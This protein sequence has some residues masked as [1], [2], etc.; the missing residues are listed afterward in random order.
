[1]PAAAPRIVL[2]T[3]AAATRGEGDSALRI[4][5][6]LAARGREVEL[7]RTTPGDPIAGAVIRECPGLD[8]VWRHPFALRTLGHDWHNAGPRVLVV[9]ERGAAEIGLSLAERH[10]IP[11]LLTVDDFLEPGERLRVSRGWC[12][13]ILAA[14]DELAHD[15]IRNVGL[16]A[17]LVHVIHP[18]VETPDPRPPA[19]EPSPIVVIG[20]AGPLSLDGG[21]GVFLAAARRVIDQGVDAE[22]IIAGSGEDEHE[23]RRRAERSKIVERVT[24]VADAGDD[25][26]FWD[27]LDIYCQPSIVPT[28][29]RG[30]RHALARGVPAIASDVDGVRGLL[31]HGVTGLRV[32]PDDAAALAKA[33]LDLIA[34]P[35]LAA[36][37]GEAG[38]IRIDRDFEPDF[39]IERLLDLIDGCLEP[40]SA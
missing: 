1:M 10:R 32:P 9:L 2:L 22:F 23:L 21:F 28:V 36:S 11:Y 24:F 17:R 25:E 39:E 7:I 8:S 6:G 15:L 3:R 20:A 38:R 4:V 40:A 5:E 14:N 18:G 35:V 19:A 29:G 26:P 13:G 34:D 30:L 12:R 33:I 37:F 16:P 27:V 31:E